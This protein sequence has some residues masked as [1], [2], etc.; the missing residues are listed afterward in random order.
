MSDSGKTKAHTIL[1]VDHTDHVRKL[2]VDILESA[3][4]HVLSSDSAKNGITLSDKTKG[5]IDML[6][7]EWDMPEMSGIALGQALKA[8]RPNLHVMHMSGGSH[9]S[10]LILNYGWAY[11][12]KPSVAT[13]LVEMVNEVFASP[14]RSQLGGESFDS[15]LD[16]N[17][18]SIMAGNPGA[19]PADS[20][21]PNDRGK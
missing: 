4:F 21:E 18:A 8:V 6:I 13:R 14:D 15:R 12:Q 10:L 5:K 3:D 2:V 17:P 16:T 20:N 7:S 19:H 1:V 9:D 11:L